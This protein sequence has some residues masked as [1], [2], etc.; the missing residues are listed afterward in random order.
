MTGLVLRAGRVPAGRATV[1]AVARATVQLGVVGLLLH[2]VITAP[3]AVGVVLAVMLTTAVRTAAGRLPDTQRAWRAVAV[4]CGCG[5][6]SSLLV[7]F[8]LGVL[9]AD[10]RYLVACG[11]IVIGA[12]MTGT[13]LAGRR[14]REGLVAR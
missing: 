1:V 11:G 4:A 2:G 7:I 9:P 3:A 10:P 14:F 5:A 8:L 12:S 6:G 13:T